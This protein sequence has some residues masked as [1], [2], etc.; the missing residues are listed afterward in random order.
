MIELIY[1]VVIISAV[2][3]NDSVTHVHTSILFFFLLG[4]LTAYGRSQARDSSQTRVV[5]YAAAVAMPDP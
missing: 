3:Q 2:Q 5:T 4:A 1:N